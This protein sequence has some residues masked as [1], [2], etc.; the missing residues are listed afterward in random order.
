MVVANNLLDPALDISGTLSH[1]DNLNIT[2]EAQHLGRAI[3]SGAAASIVGSVPELTISGLVGMSGDSVGRSLTI[4]GAASVGNNG[5]FLITSFINATSVRIENAAGVSGDLNNGVIGWTERYPW[6]AEDDHNFHRT[7]R[8]AIKGGNYDSPIP[9]YVRCVDQ[10]TLIPANLL[11]IAGNTTDAKA[12]VD[13][14]KFMDRVVNVGDTFITL[15]S[16]G[17]LKH[18]DAV[19]ITG[20]PVYDG[21]DVGDEESTFVG[22]I[23]D[24]YGAELTVLGGLYSGWRIYGRTRGGA[25]VSPNSVEIEF[26]AVSVGGDLATSVSYT[27]EA[28]QPGVVHLIIGYRSPLKDL[29]E[30]AF[31]RHL[32]H[33]ILYGG[34]GGSGGNLPVPTGIGQVLFAIEANEFGVAMPVTSQEGW[35][36]NEDGILI[37]NE[38]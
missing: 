36:V 27:W 33:S 19:N 30:I 5:T 22:I 34:E 2:E 38:V 4:S 35:L 12:F 3:Q 6:T 18:A 1:A 31:R 26:R 28:G 7:D 32:I 14:L 13:N 8:A 23:S 37:V 25:S 16:A 21:H 24:G 17:D 20:V 11:N 9:S 10:N 15:V 29:S